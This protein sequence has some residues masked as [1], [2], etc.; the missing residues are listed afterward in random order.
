MKELLTA[1]LLLCL[2]TASIAQVQFWNQDDLEDQGQ[3]AV[4]KANKVSR[5]IVYQTNEAGRVSDSSDME[6]ISNYNSDGQIVSRFR[7]KYNWNKKVNELLAVDSF[8]YDGRGRWSKY[9]AYEGPN[10][11]QT[12]ESVAEFNRKGQTVKVS[13]YNFFEGPK[14]LEGY[15]VFTWNAKNQPIKLVAY[16]ADKKKDFERSFTYDAMGNL[17]SHSLKDLSV[18][19][20]YLASWK[21]GQLATY[22]QKTDK[23][24]V[25]QVTYTAD[26]GGR[27]IK[28]ETKTSTEYFDVTE[29]RYN[30]D[31]KLPS[32]TYLQYPGYGGKNDIRHEYRVFV[33]RY[34]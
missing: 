3:S 34:F 30:G 15:Q 6:S 23:S 7:Y 19:D 31:S 10:R 14:A 28:K 21:S 2:S 32:F 11:R 29:Y 22:S 8:E 9:F 1:F 5:V 16:K 27:R 12:Y 20:V 13:N 17:V 25:K 4:R 26:A 33:Y 18:N 24:P